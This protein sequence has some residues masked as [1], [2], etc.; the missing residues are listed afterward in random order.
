MT[1]QDSEVIVWGNQTQ[2]LLSRAVTRLLA[3]FLLPVGTE[4]GTAIYHRSH[5]DETR[6]QSLSRKNQQNVP[7][8]G[9]L[10]DLF[11]HLDLNALS[12]D[13]TLT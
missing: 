10:D 3:L 8:L 13:C 12:C 9:W 4:L 7:I 5:E 2:D 6:G 11:P 1:L